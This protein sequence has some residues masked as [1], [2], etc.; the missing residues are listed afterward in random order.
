MRKIWILTLTV[1]LLIM[2][3]GL[4][5][6]HGEAEIYDNVLRLHVLANSDSENDQALN[7]VGDVLMCMKMFRFIDD[8]P[9]RFNHPTGQCTAQAFDFHGLSVR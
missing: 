3:I 7:R 8:T 5:P 2:A 9:V 4:L 1:C 6:I